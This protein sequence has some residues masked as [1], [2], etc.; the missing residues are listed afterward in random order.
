MTRMVRI[1]LAVV[2][3]SLFL[4]GVVGHAGEAPKPDATFRVE[5]Q[6]DV[7]AGGGMGVTW[8]DGTLTMADG[9]KDQFSL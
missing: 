8:G 9:S 1:L 6:Q 4:V 5:A 3:V 2:T 7:P